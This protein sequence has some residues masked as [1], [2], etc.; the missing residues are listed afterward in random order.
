MA[1]GWLLVGWLG[2]AAGKMGAGASVDGARGLGALSDDYASL[3]ARTV[4]LDEGFRDKLYLALQREADAGMSELIRDVVGGVGTSS[5]GADRDFRIKLS[6]DGKPVSLWHDVPLHPNQEDPQHSKVHFCC[7]IPKWTKKKFELATS[8]EGNPIKQDEKNGVLR[9]FKTGAAGLAFNYGFF[10]QTWEDPSLLHEDSKTYG[11]NDPL[12]ACEIGMRQ[13]PIGG[14]RTVK[15]LGVL[16]M[17]DEGETDWK[18]ICIDSSDPWAALL[19]NVS[20]LERALPG[21]VSMIREWFRTYKVADGKPENSFGLEERCMPRDFAAKVIHECHESWLRLLSGAAVREATGKAEQK[22]NKLKR[23]FRPSMIK[24]SEEE[25]R[26]LG[27]IN[28]K[29][30]D[31]AVACDNTPEEASSAHKP[32]LAPAELCSGAHNPAPALSSPQPAAGATSPQPASPVAQAPQSQAQ[33][34]QGQPAAPATATSPKSPNSPGKPAPAAGP[35][36][37]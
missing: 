4:K 26:R 34:R 8:E 25:M 1:A 3:V 24:L 33:Q 20:D 30:D 28:T 2:A 18:V 36:K 32:A 37:H 22:T 5:V 19:D 13:I 23:Q 12:D 31:L 29:A 14:V 15:V 27:A 7:E 16:L 9:E 11:D 35:G 10:P 21:T 17:V 6:K